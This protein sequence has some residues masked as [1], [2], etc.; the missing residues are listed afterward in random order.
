MRGRQV[1]ASAAL[2]TTL[3]TACGTS[4]GTGPA[5]PI[6][7]GPLTCG[8]GEYCARSY[9]S[10]IPLYDVGP[11]LPIEQLDGGPPDAGEAGDASGDGGD[12]G[13]APAT[14]P[15]VCPSGY[16]SCATSALPFGCATRTPSKSEPAQTYACG[17]ARPTAGGCTQDDPA[18]D[19]VYSCA[20]D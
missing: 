9:G 7:C 8:A 6:A 15:P 4:R 20:R 19:R 11:C 17:T 18:N 16:E 5:G 14:P 3:A 1:F 2:V 13:N 12:G 10:G